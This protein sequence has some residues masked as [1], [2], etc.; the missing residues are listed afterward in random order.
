MPA[1]DKINNIIAIETSCDE[2][3]IAVYSKINGLLAHKVYSQI[4]LHTQYG[5]VVPE[6]ASRDHIRK[7]L[8]LIKET[9]NQAKLELKDISGIAYTQ[10]PGLIGALLVGATI[11]KTLAFSLQIPTIGVHH[12]EGH[13]LAPF[14]EKDLEKEITFPFLALLV[15][16]GHTLLIKV[17]SIGNYEILGQSIDDAAGEA[18]DKTAKIL[19]LPYPGGPQIEKLAKQ[20]VF[21]KYIFPRPLM[22]NLKHNNLNFSFSGLK[23]FALNT[24]DKIKQ[25]SLINKNIN[26]HQE[27]AEIAYAFQEAVTDVF[28]KKCKQAALSTGIDKLIIAGG[29][30]ANKYLRDKF[31]SLEKEIKLKTYYPSF[32]FC[33]DNAAMI[34]Y[35]GMQRLL[36]GE[37]SPLDTSVKPKWPLSSLKD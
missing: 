35:A 20:A 15:S 7:I 3:A 19:G 2:T 4:E 32:E 23:T 13:L 29:V 10:G 16:G 22:K 9:L 14:L 11:A 31:N 18:F 30:S 37:H 34:A 36:K 6:L 1:A 24:F 12:M 28:I 33:T 8:P 25:E 5:G 26:L 21:K 27:K 17:S